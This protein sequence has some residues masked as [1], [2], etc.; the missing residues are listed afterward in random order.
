MQEK[1]EVHIDNMGEE[2]KGSEE[3]L[4]R[5]NNLDN[6]NI[7]GNSNANESIDRSNKR[8]SCRL[9]K[10]ACIFIIVGALAVLGLII[11][12]VVVFSNKETDKKKE[13]QT[14]SG[15][16]GV[17]KGV[18]E[19]IE[20]IKKEFDIQTKEK[21]LKKVGVTQTSYEETSLNGEIYSK[22]YHGVVAI[23]DECTAEGDDC[24][25]Q[26]L[27]DL[28]QAKN[29]LRN[30][31]HLQNSE[32]FKDQPVALCLFDITDNN[33]IT[34]F[35]CPKS[36]SYVKRNE[37]ILDLYFFRPPAAERPDKIG[38]NITLDITK[39]KKTGETLIHE[40]NSGYCN[41]YN[42]WVSH[43][44][45]DMNTTLDKNNNLINYDEQAYT[46]IRY[47]ELNSFKKN[48]ITKLVD[49]SQNI[50]QADIDNFEKS[51]NNLLPLLDPYMDPEVQFT[52]KDYQDLYNVIKDKK[53]SNEEQSYTPKKTKNTFRN[54]AQEKIKQ[55]KQAD[56][57]ND[58]ITPIQ[59]N[60]ALKIN[61][62][63]NSDICGAYAGI[64][65]DN[66][67]EFNF[68]SVEEA[69]FVNDLLEKLSKLSKSGN[70][71]AS[72]LY[73]SIYYKL[74]DIVNKLTIK[75]NS[76]E[77]YL[78]YYDLISVFNSTLSTYSYKQ[79]P[80]D[81]V[82]ISNELVRS[83]T[84]ILNN[85]KSGDIRINAEI[86]GND[87]NLYTS[88]IQ[89]LIRTMLNNLATLSNTLLTKNN[90]F[91]VITNYYLNNTSSSLVNKVI[92]IL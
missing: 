26:P 88:T 15:K 74:E 72:E 7:E 89:A 90:T 69:S 68:S 2:Y 56:I 29:N 82:R 20:P 45:T 24:E 53:K 5:N 11:A 64:I 50:K 40:T 14:S 28:V 51:L 67:E 41:I 78:H 84:N 79:L 57:F 66:K 33:V 1:E 19:K 65:F 44:T 76:L 3:E 73:D 87:I 36:L 30:L 58:R 75:I 23:K 55:I 21:D 77:D 54:L 8:T 48:K 61:S 62:G 13:Q 4:P 32:I 80:S 18:E 92:M 70:S 34:N 35:T 17:G 10:R 83:L 38:D 52:E 63:I 47:D 6:T 60:L 31:R 22:I 12:L 59:V 85:I 81:I 43:C 37:I 25:P 27:V 91:T 9:T 42:N 39:D 49:N 46:F 86:I 71:L 16:E